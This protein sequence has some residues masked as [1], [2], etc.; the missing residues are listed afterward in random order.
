MDRQE[1][2]RPRKNVKIDPA[3]ET[4]V[5]AA[6]L[7]ST[8]QRTRILRL[9]PKDRW[10]L[11]QHRSAVEALEELERR[12]LAFD[13][14]ALQRLFPDVDVR[15]LQELAESRPV[16][17]QDLAQYVELVRW[18]ATRADVVNGPLGDLVE[19]IAD[20]KGEPGK[21]R[22]LAKAVQD[23]FGAWRDQARVRK[24]D[25]VYEAMCRDLDARLAGHGLFPYGIPAIDV[26]QDEPG[27]PP[28]AIPG[29]KPGK[30]T[31]ITGTPGSG[32]STLA[33][34][35]ALGQIRRKR[36]VLYGAWEMTGEESLE[37][38]AIMS[39]AEEGQ[40]ISRT[41][42]QTGKGEG[43]E[44]MFA[45]VKERARLIKPFVRFVDNPFQRGQKKEKRSNDH[46][47]DI[48]EHLIVDAGADLF[49]ADLWERCLVS[50]ENEDVKQA[51]FD[52]QKICERTK[53]HGL[54]LHQQRKQGDARQD[55]RPTA[56]GLRGTGGWWDVGDTIFGTFRPG[57]WKAVPDD[58]M[59]TDFLKQRWGQWPLSVEVEFDPDRALFGR[60]TSV[61]YDQPGS[62]RDAPNE[63]DAFTGSGGG[64]R[65][66][67]ATSTIG[68]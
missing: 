47:L 25:D 34:R 52:Q 40:K 13:P 26:Y 50:D 61:P 59:V 57:Q 31:V 68:R 29:C 23:G 65:R 14:A 48:I 35:I 5:L 19:A 17:H 63:L 15:Y 46:N 44:E 41:R 32:K 28:R 43:V 4:V 55:P 20:P 56:A 12:K 21:I 16:P 30:I 49:I 2:Q 33:C 18:D 9:L 24:P 3:A 58:I 51:L 8:Q 27:Q 22:R 42:L 7:V 54:L 1:Q 62:S 64:G 11:P 38:L 10:Q 39:L 36:R 45:L 6:M 60:G 37:L 67:P 66:K 53:C